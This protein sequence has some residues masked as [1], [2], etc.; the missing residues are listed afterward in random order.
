MQRG[1]STSLPVFMW[2][3][4]LGLVFFAPVR[5]VGLRV[6]LCVGLCASG[7]VALLWALLLWALLWALLLALPWTYCG[8]SVGLGLVGLLG[9]WVCG[10]EGL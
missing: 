4:L 5:L 8:P 1:L 2:M 9:L 7:L 10:P 3:C 6:G